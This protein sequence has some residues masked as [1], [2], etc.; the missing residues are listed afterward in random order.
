MNK[1]REFD[2][3]VVAELKAA[4]QLSH[5]NLVKVI[6]LTEISGQR[7]SEERR[8]GKECRSGWWACH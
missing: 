7:R 6:G 2:Q 8:G 5:P 4:S 1:A 3:S